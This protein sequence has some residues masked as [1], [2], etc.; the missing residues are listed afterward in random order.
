M[1]H[2]TVSCP[3]CRQPIL[4]EVTQLFDVSADPRLKQLLLS[5]GA[6]VVQCPQCGYQGPLNLPIV[7]HDHAKEL[8]L[9][10][11]PPEAGL[12]VH[13]Q[14][15]VFGPLINQVVNRLPAE[16]RKAYL[17]QP[18]TMF[19]FQSMIDRIMEADGIT[20]EMRQAQEARFTVLKS[21]LEKQD[22]DIDALIEENKALLDEDFFALLTQVIQMT[23]VQGDKETTDRL[24]QIQNQ[25]TEKTEL[26]KKLKQQAEKVQK[27]LTK[28]Q[29][30]G[31]TELTR[32]KL[33]DFVIENSDDI[34]LNAIV[35]SIRPAMDYLFFQILSQKI[36]KSTDEEKAKLEAL[37]EKLLTMTAAVDKAMEAQFA[38]SRQTLER[39]LNAPD[40]EQELMKSVQEIDELFVEVLRTEIQEATKTQNNDRLAKLNKIIEILQ[41]LNP[42]SKQIELVEA[43]LDL[44]SEEEQT[45]LLNENMDAV[46]EEMVSLLSNVIAQ[47]ENSG[48]N[49]PELEKIKSLFK[50]VLKT[51]MK[52]KMSGE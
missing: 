43:L 19:S 44:E 16:Q 22:G 8:L 45:A 47:A 20:K 11:F 30:L 6:N 17:F 39:I 5:G 49:S 32:E 18:Q 27:T 14:E 46:N 29:E 21:F 26:G 50:L 2:T 34:Q 37:R 41:S 4:A 25:L 9:T 51:S 31:K 23:A 3:R 52:K 13:E 1:P 15:K 40:L 36:E 48:Q 38:Q 42:Q 24:V 33:L 35:S 10:Y 7:Y 12:P 28:L